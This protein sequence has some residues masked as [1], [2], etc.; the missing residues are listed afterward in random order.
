M[1]F[2]LIGKHKAKLVKVDI[3][4]AKRGQTDVV[5]A[6][7]LTFETA[8]PNSYLNMLDNGL[9]PLLYEK[10][11]SSAQGT[12]DGIS[13][14]SDM[15][16]LTRAASRLGT[17][18]WDDEQT[19]SGLVIYQGISGDGDIRLK[20]GAVTVKKIEA[21]EGGAWDATVLY[22]T[23]DIDAETLGNLGVLK[24]HDVD[25]EITAAAVVQRSIEES[26]DTKK[27]A[28]TN[29]LPFDAD[30]PGAAESPFPSTPEAAL[31]AAS[32]VTVTTKQSKLKAVGAGAAQ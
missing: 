12:L 22:Y 20:G 15:P 7:A 1:K 10:G 6:V 24:S 21:H 5:P 4:S 30:K 8:L 2:E 9:L 11:A 28:N 17:L 13:V 16:A 29:P 31:A 25:I 26:D 19:G 3:Q 27:D 23:E 32:G 18:S 14:V